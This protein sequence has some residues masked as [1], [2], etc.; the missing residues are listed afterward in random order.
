MPET[1]QFV[2]CD[3][4]TSKFRLQLVDRS[5]LEVISEHSNSMGVRAVHAK[6][7]KQSDVS[8]KAFFIDFL[9]RELRHIGQDIDQLPLVISGMA[10]S[11]IGMQEMPYAD[12]PFSNDGRELL[13]QKI[14][15]HGLTIILISG[16]KSPDGMMRGEETQAIGLTSLLEEY[17]DYCLLLPGT[18]SKHL[19]YQNAQ[20]TTLKNYMTGELFEVLSQ[21]SILAHSVI[22]TNLDSQKID[23][24]KQGLMLGFHQPLLSVL[25]TVRVKDVIENLAPSHNYYLLSGLL[26]GSELCGLQKNSKTIVLGCHEPLNQLYKIGLKLF[27]Q[28]R[29]LIF[30]DASAMNNAILSAH[31]TILDH[32]Y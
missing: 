22:K 3:W 27:F 18:H 32:Y 26:I 5:S 2:S 31:K 21:H 6:Y 11:S 24:F 4:G 13:H 15:D 29:K 19:Q 8:R 30:L 16:V 14:T 10:S 7:L 25:L 20:F 9:K 12:F 17:D 23:V 28:D 1:N